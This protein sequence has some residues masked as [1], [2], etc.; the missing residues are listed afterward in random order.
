[1]NILAPSGG[2]ITYR[3]YSLAWRGSIRSGMTVIAIIGHI[4]YVALGSGAQLTVQG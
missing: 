3:R 4:L 1:L 2:T